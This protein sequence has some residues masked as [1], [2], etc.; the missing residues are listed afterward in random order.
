MKIG[1]GVQ[2]KLQAAL[3][4]QA[5]L[6]YKYGWHAAQIKGEAKMGSKWFAKRIK[7]IVEEA[8]KIPDGYDGEDLFPESFEDDLEVGEA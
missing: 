3:F 1:L 6:C 4:D 7:K 8:K 2:K 5:Y